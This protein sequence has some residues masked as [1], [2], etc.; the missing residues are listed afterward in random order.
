LLDGAGVPYRCPFALCVAV[1]P[2]HVATAEAYRLVR[3][4]DTVRP[5]LAAAVRSDDLDRWRRAVTNDFG[6]PVV[7]RHPAIA[8][9]KRALLDAGAGWA[10]M[11]GSGSAVVGAF[12]A[13]AA[14][15]AA[16]EALAAAG[17][18][19]WVEPPGA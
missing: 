11:S 14:A 7:A 15:G 18:R 2:V 9:A 13:P 4:D 1:P 10:A 19:V 6:G 3:P 12:E 5:D 16:A 17:C 8:A